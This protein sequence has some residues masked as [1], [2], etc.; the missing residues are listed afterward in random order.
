MTDLLNVVVR[1][2]AAILQ[3]LA[4]EDQALLVRRDALLVLDL[5]LDIVDRVRGLNLEGDGLAR[6]GLHEAV[7][8]IGVS[9]YIFLPSQDF[10]VGE[11]A[12]FSRCARGGWERPTS[13]LSSFRTVSMA[14]IFWACCKGMTYFCCDFREPAPEGNDEVGKFTS[15]INF[16]GV[17]KFSQD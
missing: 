3:L 16:G 17:R 13:A 9:L 14:V 6:E 15:S 10:G 12:A 2:G 4:S 5:G 7:E 11:A 1:K 8:S